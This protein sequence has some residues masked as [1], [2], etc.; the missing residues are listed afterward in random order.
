MASLFS[1]QRLDDELEAMTCSLHT[2][3]FSIHAGRRGDGRSTRPEPLAAWDVGGRG[4]RRHRVGTLRDLG[5]C[6]WGGG[7]VRTRL[8]GGGVDRL[9]GGGSVMGTMRGG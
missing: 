8:D 3:Y 1:R 9:E 4:R 5:V 7:G 6:V 2:R